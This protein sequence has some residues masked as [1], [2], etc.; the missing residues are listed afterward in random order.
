MALV[1]FC[2]PSLSIYLSGWVRSWLQHVG[3]LTG[4]H[5]LSLCDSL[6]VACRLSSCVTQDL[7]L[8]DI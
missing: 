5:G 8:C 3:S 6:A 7:L 4:A 2:P 1:A